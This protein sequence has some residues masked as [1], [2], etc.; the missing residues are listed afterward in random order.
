MIRKQ[1]KLILAADPCYLI[2]S[3]P[4]SLIAIAH[5]PFQPFFTASIS[6]QKRSLH[7]S[8]SRFARS[9]IIIGIFYIDHTN[10]KPLYIAMRKSIFLSA[11]TILFSCS[12]FAQ[13]ISL[14]PSGDNQ[15]CEITQH[16]GLV[17]VT[18]IYNSPDVS[19]SNGNS[20]RGKIWG[21]LVPY[22][23]ADNNFGTAKKIPWR[24]GA[25]ENTTIEFSH[26][27]KIEGMEIPAGKYG[28]H[29]IPGL[30]TWMIIFSKNSSAW[31]SYFYDE[32]E[33]ALR[34]EVT[35]KS[36]SFTEWL[37]YDFIEKKPT[38]TVAA[39]KWEEIMV[40]F[41]IEAEVIDLYLSQIRSE[42]QNS[43]GFIWQ[44]WI[45]A[46][47]FCIQNNVNLDEA[48][49]WADYAIS[50]P[51]VGQRNFTTLSTKANLLF[52]LNRPGE[53]IIIVKKAIDEPTATVQDIHM[54]GRKLIN[55]GRAEQAMK[56]FEL[57]HQ[58]HPDDN[59]TTYIGLAIGYES[60]GKKKKAIKNYRIA[61]ENA[62]EGQRDYY[63]DLAKNLE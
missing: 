5:T 58:K 40:P 3:I 37:T 15:K 46:I 12:V 10:M 27:V 24:A 51:F 30:E 19:D 34:V 44:N 29:M 47:N 48:L 23:L 14:P 1:R 25:N 50:A 57:N 11:L 2:D 7:L 17:E 16:I 22:G 59:F 8:I 41:K 62:P 53:A 31:G 20:R 38:Y 6:L 28:L 33:D 26:D 60:L 43:P 18:I 13:S 52:E 45:A 21:G 9:G 4:L 61:A 56:V 35:P 63:L 42:L 55:A 54:F 49:L 32:S 36:N 39:L